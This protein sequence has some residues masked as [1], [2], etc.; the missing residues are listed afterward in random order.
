MLTKEEFARIQE[1]CIVGSSSV[2][3]DETIVDQLKIPFLYS[4]YNVQ[5]RYERW[6]QK[7]AEKLQANAYYQ[8][9]HWAESM[10]GDL[11]F[12]YI[13]RFVQLPQ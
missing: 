12:P 3:I 9:L 2:L 4:R 8:D 10:F 5:A 11:P 7:E 6:L 1:R 13:I